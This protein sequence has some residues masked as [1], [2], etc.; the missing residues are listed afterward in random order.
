MTLPATVVL[1]TYNGS[2]FLAAT[3]R[4]IADQTVRPS[5]VILVDD[6]STDGTPW[7]AESTCRAL[8][9]P[10]RVVVRPT[11]S[12][13]PAVPMND[14]VALSE[15]EVVVLQ[16]QDDLMTPRRIELQAGALADRADAALVFGWIALLTADDEW[17]EVPFKVPPER[18]RAV[19]GEPGCPGVRWLDPAAFYADTLL[20]GNVIGASNVAFRKSAWAAAGGFRTDLRVI[21]D[22]DFACRVTR[23]GR[24]GF[25]DHQVAW[26]RLH[27][28]NLHTRGLVCDREWGA[29]LRDHYRRPLW[30]IDRQALRPVL[31]EHAFTLAYRESVRGSGWRAEIGF[32]AA[33]RYG[34]DRLRCLAGAGKVPLHLFRR[35]W[36]SH[37]ARGA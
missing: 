19:A 20:N 24:V 8:G 35:L 22:Y 10:A 7:L 11:N 27:E 2:G 37:P 36:Q 17:S 28:G 15:T 30:P 14:G 32:A 34:A 9:L 16:D 6:A 13:G 25:V 1:P 12:G 21:W 3:L 26:Y 23:L 5:E 31:A 33:L 18:I 4:S 29:L